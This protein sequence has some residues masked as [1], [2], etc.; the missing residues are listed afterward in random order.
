MASVTIYPA[1]PT[2]VE[3]KNPTTNYHT[4][5]YLY[6]GYG[7]VANGIF[8]TLIDLDLSVI[9]DK[10]VIKTARMH[11]YQPTGLG[12]A[13]VLTFQAHSITGVLTPATVTWNTQPA[14]E[15]VA[16]NAGLTCNV[17][18]APIWRDWDVATLITEMLAND[19]DGILLKSSSEG[20]ENDKG[21]YSSGV[22]L[23]YFVIEY[24][25]PSKVNIGDAWKPATNIKVNV[26]DAWKPASGM[27]VNIGDAW[28]EVF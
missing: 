19:Y 15:A 20:T 23:M 27:K 16:A 24:E 4:S 7:G 25:L 5:S 12:L 22:M 28:K 10:A 2:R 21:F 18:G 14:I 13:G 8:R 17:T 3:S 6:V 26:G 11:I 1:D 9:P